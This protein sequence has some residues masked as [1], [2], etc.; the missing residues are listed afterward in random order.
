MLVRSTAC[1][2]LRLLYRVF[3]CFFVHYLLRPLVYSLN[4][5]LYS[6]NRVG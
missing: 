2:F 3:V 5:L 4:Y 1:S 6:V